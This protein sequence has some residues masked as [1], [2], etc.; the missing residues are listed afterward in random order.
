VIGSPRCSA[1]ELLPRNINESDERCV[2]VFQLLVEAGCRAEDASC[3]LTE[4]WIY[5]DFEHAPAEARP[6][7]LEQTRA[8]VPALLDQ[9]EEL[10]ARARDVLA[11]GAFDVEP[12]DALWDRRR[13]TLDRELAPA[14]RAVGAATIIAPRAREHRPRRRN[15]RLATAGVRGPP[16]RPRLAKTGFA[17]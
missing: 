15:R 3:F 14:R 13:H 16:D 1:R 9:A 17:R 12:D 5:A 7:I 4:P 10:V 2:A 8:R 6:A 11:G